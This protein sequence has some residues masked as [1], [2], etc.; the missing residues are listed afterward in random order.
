MSRCLTKLLVFW[1][2]PP[3]KSTGLKVTNSISATN[4]VQLQCTGTSE[5]HTSP[6]NLRHPSALSHMCRACSRISQA[7]AAS[8]TQLVCTGFTVCRWTSGAE[9]AHRVPHILHTKSH[10]TW[11]L[12]THTGQST[13]RSLSGKFWTEWWHPGPNRFVQVL[14][15][16]VK[17]QVTLIFFMKFDHLAIR[18]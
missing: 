13:H 2:A 7:H 9:H 4:L 14:L 12:Q 6:V 17:N 11:T 3:W 15:K 1:T 18:I 16:C 5:T 8:R 10:T